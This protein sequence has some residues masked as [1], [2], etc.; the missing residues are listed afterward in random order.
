MGFS[1]DEPSANMKRTY[2][3]PVSSRISPL[4]RAVVLVLL[5]SAGSG[6]FAQTISGTSTSAQT[7]SSGTLTISPGATLNVGNDKVAITVTGSSTIIN[8]GTV[9]ELSAAGDQKGR[10][11]RDNTGNLVVTIN[12][13]SSTN[14]NALI[15]TQDADDIQMNV[16]GTTVTLNN[17]GTITSLNSSGSGNQAVD[18]NA[19]TQNVQNSNT[20]NNFSTGV[21]TAAEA[22]AVRPGVNGVIN[23]AGTIKSTTSTGSSSDGIDAQSNT[24]ISIVNAAAAL[25]SAAGTNLIEGGRHGITGGNTTGNGAYSMSVTNNAGGTIQGDNG[26]GINIDGING[27]ELVTIVNKGLISG[28]GITGDGDGVDVDGLVNL[29]NSGTIRSL[30]SFAA[31]G[32]ETSEGVTVGGG[33]IVNSG[34]I[35]GSVASGNTSAVGRGITIAGVDKDA[36]GASIPV[37]A[38]YAATTITNS[39]L[40]RGD[41]DSAIAFS[42]GLS[43]GFT[44]TIDNQAGGVLQGGGTTAAAIVTAADKVIIKNAGTIDGSSSGKAISGGSAGV[45][46]TVTGGSATILGDIGGGGAAANNTAVLT[47]GTGNT[48]SY[49][50]SISN[51]SS[52]DVQSGKV[53]LSGSNAYTGTTRVSGGVLNLQGANRLAQGSGLDLAGGTLMLS[54]ISGAEGQHLASL[55]LSASS[56]LDLG[57]SSMTFDVLSFLSAGSK[58]TITDWSAATS[59]DYAIRFSGDQTA[60]SLFLSLLSGTTVDGL[61][62]TFHYDGQFTDISAVPLPGAALL[63]LSGAGL[64]LGARRRSA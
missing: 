42:S 14:S 47:P 35:Q 13:G 30:N 10:A 48:F 37:Q 22:D 29:N 6:A 52:V 32:K 33:T 24:G 36:K 34:T 41:S 8:N 46:L 62:A 43:S 2:N 55:G 1:D 53:T 38:P 16:A 3:V 63:L 12:N 56:G 11:I 5:A 40:I 39:G 45:A 44:H 17:Y 50:G 15:K 51:F 31:S 7:L 4:Q 9:E 59:P 57:G 21:I 23:N 28:S 58:L 20:L 27:N 25:G 19:L 54:G 61:A 64:I 26:S 49:A 60:N 18:W